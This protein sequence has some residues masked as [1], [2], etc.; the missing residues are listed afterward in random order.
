VQ[1]THAVA[2]GALP[3]QH[4]ALGGE[5]LVRRCVTTTSQPVPAATCM[6]GLRHRAQV[7]H[8]VVDDRDRGM[9]YSDPLVDGM[10]PAE[11]GSGV[12]AMR[13]ARAKALNTVSHWWWALSPLRLS[14]CS[15]T[16]AWFTKPW[17]NS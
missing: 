16:S 6:H 2:H 10:T 13:R 17:K 9:V 14:M 12:S 5:H 7:A 4:D 8:A 11:R 15:V 1:F 3:W